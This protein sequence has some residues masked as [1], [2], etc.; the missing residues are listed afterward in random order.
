MTASG[1]AADVS[2]VGK[3]AAGAF[4]Y[5]NSSTIWSFIDWD[6]SV[7]YAAGNMTVSYSTDKE[8]AYEIDASVSMGGGV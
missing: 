8:D 6:A 5:S 2:L 1:V 7:S 3:A 4:S